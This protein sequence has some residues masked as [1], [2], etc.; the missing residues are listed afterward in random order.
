MKNHPQLP[1]AWADR[2]LKWLTPPHLREELLGDLHEQFAEQAEAVGSRKARRLY[3]LEV[4]KFVRPFYIRERLRHLARLS[5]PDAGYAR[6]EIHRPAF[7]HPTDMFRN[8]LKIA[9]RNLWK[10]KGYA[11]INVVGL[12]VAFCICLFLFLTAYLQL[13]YDAFHRDGDRI[14]QTYFVANDPERVSKTGGMPLPLTPALKSEFPEVEA[15]ARVL[16][17]RKSSVEW[18]GKGFEKLVLMT[19]PDFFKVFT[20]PMVKGNP[21]VALLELSSIVLSETTARTVFGSEDPIGKPIQIG[22]GPDRKQYIVSGIVADPPLNSTIQF[23]ALTRIENRPGYASD[24]DNWNANSS[25]VF[26]KT[27]P[28]VAQ[29]SVENRLK[30]FI[31]KY[32]GGTIEGLKKKGARPDDRG[33][34]F[35]LRLQKLADVHFSREINGGKG[36]PIALIYILI[37]IGAFILLIA[38]INFIN[39][40]IA[41]S[42]TR[43][44]EVGVRKSLGALKQQLFVQIWGESSVV[45]F[46]GF[47]TGLLLAFFL[48]PTFNAVFQSRLSLDHVF[49]P[50]F[51]AVI[52]GVFLLVSLLAGGYPALQMARFNPVEVL[53]GKVSLKRPGILRN[54]LIVTQFAMS[55]LLACAT[56]VAMQQ[57][58]FLRQQ[59][60][61]FQ[62]E[63]VVSLPVGSQSD[64]R[65]VLQRL[66]ARLADDP[67]VVSVTG[68]GVNLG[69][70]KDRVSSR[71][72]FGFTYKGKG[73]AT[74]WLLIDYDYLKTL[75]IKL[76]AG[77]DFDPAYRTDSVSRIIVTERMA[78]ALGLKN[79]V[80][81]FIK[82]DS[83]T[84]GTPMQIIGLVQNFR[85]YS[86][87]EEERPITMHLSHSE[88]IHYIFVRV[89]P[90]SLS[91][92]MDKLKA[93]WSEVAPQSEFMASFLDENID[94]WYQN[95][96]MMSRLFSV[97][98]GIAI[99]LSCIGL[100]AV[101]LM[102][103][104]QRTKEIGIR[105]V[106][107][108][109]VA[110]IVLILSRDFVKL[111]LIALLISLPLAW[112]GLTMWLN[113]YA[114]RIE[115]S[116]WVFGG[117]GLSALLIA[118]ATVSYQSIKTAL[119]NPVRSLRSE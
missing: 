32:L 105:K 12:S 35:A 116:P 71:S 56:V 7:F 81:A 83:D 109:G 44:R 3:A 10:S 75:N 70:G 80:G 94:A 59:P 99:L 98:A 73:V 38:C 119:M 86:L 2:L 97:A 74:D 22:T 4:L 51:L 19:D 96:A 31:L 39:L 108:A 46:V 118:L 49:E 11:A 78:K 23:D 13:T 95:E 33:D 77:R 93:V 43:A 26:I 82:D 20:F 63:Q 50:G 58:R 89:T 27:A 65:Q 42:F 14:Y 15:A 115:L 69:R 111:V 79:P 30:P 24:K 113:N 92:T 57:V 34:L 8:Y 41:R 17:G 67:A 54:S 28:G 5:E 53:K 106:M 117:I 55:T 9:F 47:G 36:A 87:S 40:S 66:R 91:V 6:K 104:E 107:G 48:L 52:L 101:A 84:T 18:K 88:P 103:I 60:L 62:S 21:D 16:S 1:P 110:G 45:C 68:S 85:L 100:F 72:V 90:G 25:S 76:L 29:A 64:G 114:Q 112:F 37:G 102:V 61:G